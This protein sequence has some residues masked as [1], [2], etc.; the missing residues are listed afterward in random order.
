MNTTK[1][2]VLFILFYFF[3]HISKDVKWGVLLC[4]I[5]SFVFYFIV[6]YFPEL[7]KIAGITV[8]YN[9]ITTFFFFVSAIYRIIQKKVHLSKVY[10][11][12]LIYFTF[13]IL[14]ITIS[15]V[16]YG[17]TSFVIA[18]P[19]LYF[20]AP[21]LYFSTFNYSEIELKKIWTIFGIY[22]VSLILMA[23]LR[24]LNI[25]PLNLSFE[26]A[27][28]YK[29]TTSIYFSFRALYAA[30][31]LDL[32]FFSLIV[33]VLVLN[34]KLKSFIYILLAIIS[35]I[36]VI[37][38]QQRTPWLILSIVMI[39]LSIQY[40][41]RILK[42]STAFLVTAVIIIMFVKSTPGLKEAYFYSF[43]TPIKNF[44][45]S[46][47]AERFY[48][49][50]FLLKTM[51]SYELL[52][53]KLYG[54]DMSSYVRGRWISYG[55]HLFHFSKFFYGGI[56]LFSAYIIFQLHLLGS[57]NRLKSKNRSE[58]YI[59]F[60]F[61]ILVFSNIILNFTTSPSLSA[62]LYYG[63]SLS[64]LKNTLITRS[65]NNNEKNIY[66]IANAE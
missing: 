22:I 45:G 59:Y 29:S 26:E 51:E 10:L 5:S 40:K 35:I 38:V 56:V 66:H 18:R 55:I 52:V 15:F 34:H 24:L 20:L 33:F 4:L 17:T 48:Q 65:K 28:K 42:I 39:L 27:L 6:G 50:E 60:V 8:Y 2:I 44:S 11:P 1:L 21:T 19:T 13:E 58:G 14:Y 54:A 37:I 25:I 49:A 36:F 41:K 7:F 53:G 23:F 63:V 64:L 61:F 16:S 9:D 43:I 46:T 47:G 57:L 30:Q 12:F 32:I 3:L 31:S 62:G